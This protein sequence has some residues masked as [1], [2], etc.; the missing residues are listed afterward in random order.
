MKL[1]KCQ[2]LTHNWGHILDAT[3][4]GLDLFWSDF[5]QNLERIQKIDHF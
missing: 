1:K 3:K 4:Y 2:F 5:D